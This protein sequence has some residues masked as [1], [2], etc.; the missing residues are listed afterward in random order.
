MPTYQPGNT[1]SL[2][3]TYNQPVIVTG[4]TPF[5][6]ASNATHSNA[7]PLT[8]ESG[9]GTNTLLFTANA[10]ANTTG[11]GE[12]G[13]SNNNVLI[14]NATFIN[15]LAAIIYE[16]YPQLLNL[17]QFGEGFLFGNFWSGAYSGNSYTSN[18]LGGSWSP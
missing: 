5:V 15:A 9:N 2:A 8:Y 12:I 11:N 16:N 4:N 13:I 3:I 10:Y 17:P 18:A 6:W 7:F 1:I 14:Q